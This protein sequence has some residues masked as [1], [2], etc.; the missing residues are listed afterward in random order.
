MW[1][2]ITAVKTPWYTYIDHEVTCRA[3]TCPFWRQVRFNRRSQFVIERSFGGQCLQDVRYRATHPVLLLILIR[4]RKAG[5]RGMAH[6]ACPWYPCRSKEGRS[7]SPQIYRTPECEHGI[8]VCNSQQ[9]LVYSPRII[10]LFSSI[11]FHRNKTAEV[12][13]RETAA[14]QSNTPY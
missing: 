11:I 13:S 4:C 2:R 12:V 5:K 9:M 6:L 3:L 8:S 14:T 1:I 10:T 7:W